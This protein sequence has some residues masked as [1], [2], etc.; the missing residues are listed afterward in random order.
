MNGRMKLLACAAA[1]LLALLVGATCG[2]AESTSLR[3]LRCGKAAQARQ[4]R[5]GPDVLLHYVPW[6]Q[7]SIPLTSRDVEAGPA[8]F[9]SARCEA[10]GHLWLAGQ[11]W[12]RGLLEQS[13]PQGPSFVAWQ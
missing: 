10:G 12:K 8:P 2:Y 5:L 11:T 9:P 1:V 3:C 13:G 4:L 7:R 6:A